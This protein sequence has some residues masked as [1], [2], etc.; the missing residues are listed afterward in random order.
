MP[1]LDRGIHAETM[2][3]HSAGAGGVTNGMDD[4]IKWGHDGRSGCAGSG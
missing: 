3:P 1:R 4:P 2:A